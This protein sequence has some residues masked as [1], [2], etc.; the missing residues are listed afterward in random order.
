MQRLA[1]L[2]IGAGLGILMLNWSAQKPARLAAAQRPTQITATH[3]FTGPDGMTHAENMEVKLSADGAIKGVEHSS[4]MDSGLQFAR[5]GPGQVQDWHTAGQPQ[6]AVTI[7]GRGEI[8]VAGGKKI[9]VEPGHLLFFE[10]LTGKGHIT[11]SEQH[12]LNTS[13]SS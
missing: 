9:R 11:R 6:Y 10:D 3:I 1:T 7:S 8:E 4:T 2:A 5:R 13:H 12:T